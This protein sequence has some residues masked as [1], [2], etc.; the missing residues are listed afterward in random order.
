M[1]NKFVLAVIMAL[2]AAT[3]TLFAINQIFEM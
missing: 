1:K 3:T 2:F